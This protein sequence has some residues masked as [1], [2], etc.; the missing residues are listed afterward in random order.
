MN[1][2]LTHIKRKASQFLL[3][4]RHGKKYYKKINETVNHL[5]TAMTKKFEEIV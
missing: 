3:L 5:T 1:V 4:K 2:D